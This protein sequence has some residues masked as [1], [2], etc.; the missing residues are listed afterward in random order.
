MACKLTRTL[1]KVKEV[2]PR[3]HLYI[4]IFRLGS[5]YRIPVHLFAYWLLLFKNETLI[6]IHP[7]HMQ[8]SGR[9]F[10]NLAQVW[11]GQIASGEL[12]ILTL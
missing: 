2:E 9:V 6:T 12:E 7:I 8:I 5:D 10:C 4:D 3:D 11:G 1:Y